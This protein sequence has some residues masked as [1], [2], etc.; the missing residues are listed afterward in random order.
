MTQCLTTR[1]SK[2]AHPP[3]LCNFGMTQS[4]LIR[5]YVVPDFSRLCDILWLQIPRNHLGSDLFIPK[6]PFPR[7][8]CHLNLRLRFSIMRGPRNRDYLG[9]GWSDSYMKSTSSSIQILKSS[10]ATRWELFLNISSPF[11]H[12]SPSCSKILSF[13][14]LGTIVT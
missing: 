10:R 2:S 6:Y 1:V 13:E 3:W 5:G 7:L 11:Y 8:I 14:T 4:H 12:I 9:N